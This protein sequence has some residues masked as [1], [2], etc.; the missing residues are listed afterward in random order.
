MTQTETRAN[1]LGVEKQITIHEWLEQQPKE[2]RGSLCEDADMDRLNRQCRLVYQCL[3]NLRAWTLAELSAATG[4]PAQSCSARWREIRR[5]LEAGNK[6][7]GF[8][9]KVPGK[10]GLFTYRI[11]LGKYFGA[12]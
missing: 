10:P 11:E 12:A 9:E 3:R 8:R 1:S 4:A 7:K 5:Y 2:A 6:G